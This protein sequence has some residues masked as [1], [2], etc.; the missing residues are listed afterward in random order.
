MKK[1]G[2]LFALLWLLF[3]N[4]YAQEQ[5]SGIFEDDIPKTSAKELQF[6]A[7]FIS[8]GVSSNFYP[9]NVFMRGQVIGRLFGDNTTMTSNSSTP[10]YFEQRIIPFFVYQPKLFNGKALLRA[11]FEIDFTWG[12]AAYGVGGNLGG[13]IS[14]DFVNIQTQNIEIELKPA[15]YWRVNLGLLRLYDTP[16]N[17][18]R[19]FFDKMMQSG[20][21]LSYWG[22]DA[23][24]V[25][26]HRNDDFSDFKAGF[27]QLYENNVEEKDDV[28]L[29]E[30]SYQRKL[31]NNWKLGAS[32]Y[33]INDKA[34]GE[35]G[36]SIYGQGLN[37][38]LSGYNGTFRFLDFGTKQYKADIA[39]IGTF[40]SR[41]EDFMM[42]RH[43]IN[44]FFNYNIGKAKVAEGDGWVTGADIAGFGANIRYAYRYGQTALDYISI[45]GVYTSG[46]NNALEDKKYSGVIT[47][48]QWGAPAG[49]FIGTGAYLLFPHA[50]VVNR[51]TPAIADM[52]NMG[53]G[54]TGGTINISKDIIPYKISA[55]LGFASA[56]SNVTPEGGGNFMGAEINTAAQYNFGPFMSIGVHAAYLKLGDFYDSNDSSYSF[57]VN[58]GGPDSLRPVDPW[59]AFIVFK[60]LMF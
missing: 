34:N 43:M 5:A 8:Q 15:K 47:G 44:G 17:P 36:V 1:T 19:V 33:Y 18:Y 25:A 13:A 2:F 48:N 55:K 51:F 38:K 35:G 57:D 29:T 21:R 22:T 42:D 52:S 31:K 32:L 58:G 50:N 27:Y 56:L 59:T 3:T 41:N 11:S 28:W 9:K 39:W 16:Y 12:D 20:Y 37:S 40:F 46:D 4:L 7:F 6:F 45:D 23:V 24:G 14:G 60:W 30:L 49:I 53:Y 10:K 26:A 54:I